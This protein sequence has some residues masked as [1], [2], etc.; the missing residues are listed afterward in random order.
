M[1]IG[2]VAT[3]A[4]IRGGS[5]QDVHTNLW[6]PVHAG[7]IVPLDGAYEFLH[8]RIQ[9]AAY[10]LI[11]ERERAAVHLQIGRLLSSRTFAE[12]TPRMPGMMAAAISRRR[13]MV[14]G[15]AT[16]LP[17]GRLP[18]LWSASQAVARLMMA[19]VLL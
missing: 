8:D 14:S 17:N 19:S 3:L 7:L 2:E 5:E 18:R 1:Q 13:S 11:A 16:T 12:L 9:E 10:S 4:M 6:E 15:A